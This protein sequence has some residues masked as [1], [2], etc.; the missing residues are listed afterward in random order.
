MERILFWHDKHIM[1]PKYLSF[2][3]KCHGKALKWPQDFHLIYKATRDGDTAKA[4]WGLVEGKG[5]VFVFIKSTQGKS[6][7]GYRS[8]AFKE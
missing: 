3:N 1:Q 2:I 6:F 4:Y 7:G 8:I 5:N